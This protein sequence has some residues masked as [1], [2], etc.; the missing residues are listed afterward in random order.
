M[1]F[2][3]CSGEW[4]RSIA[5]EASFSDLGQSRQNPGSWGWCKQLRHPVWGLPCFQHMALCFFCWGGGVQNRE[6]VPRSPPVLA[7]CPLIVNTASQGCS[8]RSVY[9]LSSV[10]TRCC[11]DHCFN[12]I[13][14]QVVGCLLFRSRPVPSWLYPSQDSNLW[15]STFSGC[16]DGLVK[17]LTLDLGSDHDLLVVGFS[18]SLLSCPSLAC[19]LFVSNL[20]KLKKKQVAWNTLFRQDCL[21]EGN[22]RDLSVKFPVLTR[23]FFAD[24]LKVTFLQE[25]N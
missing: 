5:T 8:P 3:W 13:W 23:K 9:N 21:S 6:M 19:A 4:A 11:T 25:W 14:L 22:G 2:H 18:L 1:G 12:A 15:N 7:L 24:W 17:C 16:L 10:C 20:N